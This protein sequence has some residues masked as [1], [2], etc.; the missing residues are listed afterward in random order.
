MTTD[1]E[2]LH[3]IGVWLEEGRT[4]LP[5][6]VLDAVLEQL[7]SKRQR[8]PVWAARRI[9]HVNALAKYA[10]AAA[11][12]VVI[13]IVGWNFVGTSGTTQPGGPPSITPSPSASTEPSSRVVPLVP[14]TNAIEPGRYRWVAPGGEV[15]MVLPA[16]WTGFPDGIS[17]GTVAENGS[18]MELGHSL[19]GNQYQVTHVYADACDSEGRLEPVDPDVESLL[20][21]LDEQASTDA[22]IE[23]F[24][25]EGGS[26]VGYRVELRPGPDVDQCRHGQGGPLQIWADPAETGFFAFRPGWWGEA[27]IFGEGDPVLPEPF[28]F[29]AAIG[30]ETTE[31]DLEELR[32]IVRS[33]E[34][35]V[36]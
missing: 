32:D 3:A 29:H 30:P 31:A 14:S 16:G 13:A 12:V 7:P 33:F 8:R 10:I 28:V 35:T 34:F 22:T 2:T 21:A 17:N 19:P 24:S 15:S 6:H 25:G 4:A 11:A 23:T 18:W 27:Y 36:P 1:R 26:P 5:D 9:S 20:S